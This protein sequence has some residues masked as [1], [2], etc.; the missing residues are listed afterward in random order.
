MLSLDV[1]KGQLNNKILAK[2]KRINCTCSFILGGT[3]GF[4]QVC[5]VAINKPLKDRIAELA[6]IHYDAHEEQWIENKY[7]VGDRRV[8][9]VSWVAQAWDDLHCYDSESIRQ[10]FR[11]VGL[12]LPTDG[13]RDDEI[14]IKDLPGIQ[15]GN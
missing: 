14:K 1:F 9:L 11:D 12:A 10:A 15:V 13:S 5:D 8:M 3:T 7:S 4:I 6:E 2:F